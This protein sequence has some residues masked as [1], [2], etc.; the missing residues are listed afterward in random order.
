MIFID[1]LRLIQTLRYKRLIFQKMKKRK[2]LRNPVLKG[3]KVIVLAERLK[4]KMLQSNYS[5]N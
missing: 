3:E 1:F 5:N 4:K 2:E